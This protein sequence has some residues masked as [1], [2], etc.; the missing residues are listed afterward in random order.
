MEANRFIC[1]AVV[2][3]RVTSDIGVNVSPEVVRAR[4]RAA[5]LRGR[6]ARKKPFLSRKH[7]RQRL[8]HAQKFLDWPEEKWR[9]VF[10]SDEA[11]VE[12]HGTSGRVSVCRRP[13]EAFDDKYVL[14]TYKSSRKSLMVW[15]SITA[16]GVGTMHFCDES[17]TGAYYRT[18]LRSNI[19]I[20]MQLLGL[21]GETV[22]VQDN[23]PA[24]RAKLHV[25]LLV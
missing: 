23:A 24:H 1:A 2:A 22:F 14:P 10:F 6:S 17:V 16:D 3:T 18:I 21:E 25:P 15:A 12:L 5:G 20:T 8:R 7:R 13:H 11:S 4:V 9:T 19:P